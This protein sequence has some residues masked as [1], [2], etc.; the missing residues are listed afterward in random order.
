MQEVAGRKFEENPE[1][2]HDPVIG[3]EL[4]VTYLCGG[5]MEVICM[6]WAKYVCIWVWYSILPV[7]YVLRVYFAES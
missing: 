6:L 7:E 1:A 5:Y 3:K 2:Q 4:Y